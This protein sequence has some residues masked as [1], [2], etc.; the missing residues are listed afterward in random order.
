MIRFVC[1]ACESVL[2]SPDHKAGKKITCPKRGCGQRLQI[3]GAAVLQARNK[4]VLGSLVASLIPRRR[5]SSVR[6]A[7]NQ[8]PVAVPSTGL[9]TP[10]HAPPALPTLS[11]EEYF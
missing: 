2:E 4:T 3:P 11:R 6:V 9:V 1:P 5:E 7:A 10:T 8:T